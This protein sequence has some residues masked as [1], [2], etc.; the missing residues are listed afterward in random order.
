M[1]QF[2][3]E[4]AGELIAGMLQ[5][6]P[7]WLPLAFGF[8]L[9]RLWLYYVRAKHIANIEWTTLEIRLAKEISKTPLAMEVVLHGMHQRGQISTFINRYWYGNLRPWFSLELISLEGNVHF[10]I[11]TP[12]FFKKIIEAQIYAQY[13]DADV[14][15]VPDYTEKVPYGISASPWQLWGVEFQLTKP[16]PYPIKTY[17]DYGLDK[18]GVKEEYKTDPMTAVL[19][20]LGSIGK[21]EQLWLQIL[22]RQTENRF[23]V[24]GAWF[25]KRGW[26]DEAKDLVDKLMKE[27]SERSK[28][29]QAEGEFKLSQQTKGEEQ[30][31]SAIERSVSKY[32]FDCGIRGLY[33]AK[34]GSFN[35]VNIV[36]LLGSMR[37]YS[38]Q[39]LNGI[40][41]GWTTS[42]DYP[43]EDYKDIRI[44]RMK[45]RIFDAYRRRSY[46]HPPYSRKPFVLNTEELATIYHFP[47]QVGETPTL[48]RIESKRAKPPSNLPI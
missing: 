21:D 39:D 6:A 44:N 30:V 15:E 22:I 31:I 41:P 23:P 14:F 45:A 37:Q 11:R 20:F 42:T 9:W 16:D 3:I 48:E 26:K 35:P 43:W 4:T 40:A 13:P 17:V 32:G 28:K 12:V 47:G 18:E 1:Q 8:I 33:L 46:F 25:G 10:L 19:E 38:S 24:P 36:G 29:R 7:Y 34:E 2:L 27:T 5:M